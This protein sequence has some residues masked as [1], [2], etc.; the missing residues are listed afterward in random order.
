MLKRVCHRSPTDQQLLSAFRRR[1]SFS[2]T[3]ELLRVSR[4]APRVISYVNGN[5]SRLWRVHTPL[6]S[7]SYTVRTY[8]YLYT[9]YRWLPS[10]AH[11]FVLV[12]CATKHPKALRVPSRFGKERRGR[13]IRKIRVKPQLDFSSK[14]RGNRQYKCRMK[15]SF[16]FFIDLKTKP[17]I[18][19]MIT[20]S[21][22]FFSYNIRINRTV[23]IEWEA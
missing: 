20:V 15:F 13:E 10:S 19:I 14:P 9:V 23:P 18:F 22:V 4:P 2:G 6:Q 16:F 3:A 21:G 7:L 11:H 1:G 8:Y 17:A 5:A 12:V